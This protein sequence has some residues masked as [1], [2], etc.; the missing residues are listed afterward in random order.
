[1]SKGFKGDRNLNG[2]PKGSANKVTTEIRDAYKMLIENNLDNL[3]DWIKT[4]AE[5]SPEK[6]IELIIKLSE[7]VVPK[8]NRT[9][10]KTTTINDL[11][12]LTREERAKRIK[13]LQSKKD[14]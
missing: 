7:Y 1:M 8:L 2:R 6:A 10:I 5:N 9:E 3:T 13:E 11:V 14:D 12:L 4:I